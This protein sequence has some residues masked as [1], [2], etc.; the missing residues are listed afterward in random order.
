MNIL[1]TSTRV[2][3]VAAMG[4]LAGATAQATLVLSTA[5][6]THISDPPP[7]NGPTLAEVATATGIPVANLGDLVY[8][9]GTGAVP[10]EEYSAA[11]YYTT[12]YS[13]LPAGDAANGFAQ[14]VW[15]GPQS[16]DATAL[17][18][19]DGIGGHYAWNLI[20]LGWDGKETIQ[21]LNPYP[22]PGTISHIDIYGAVVPEPSTYIAGGLALLPL[23]FGLRAR[24]AKK[25]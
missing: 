7:V 23:L 6:G 16:I 21:I 3:L 14:I 1:S 10:P 17:V 19:K 11:P 15:D 4:L 2:A 13:P 12:S 5:N 18:V 9:V 24:F 8:R 22:G 20:N 25:A